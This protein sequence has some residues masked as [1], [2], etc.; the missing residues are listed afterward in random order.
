MKELKDFVAACDQAIGLYIKCW[1]GILRL[2][3]EP[4]STTALCEEAQRIVRECRRQTADHTISW[5]T[6]LVEDS[7][8]LVAQELELN[9]DGAEWR[10]IEAVLSGA[11]AGFAHDRQCPPGSLLAA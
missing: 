5:F 3:F 11:A 8:R 2:P 6:E 7:R 10:R 1:D 4:L 9:P